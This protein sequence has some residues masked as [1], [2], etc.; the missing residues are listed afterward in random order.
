MRFTKD[1]LVPGAAVW[2][3]TKTSHLVETETFAPL[4]G[5]DSRPYPE[6]PYLDHALYLRH[7]QVVPAAVLQT[8]DQFELGVGW[9][10][11][12]LRQQEDTH[13][14]SVDYSLS[15]NRLLPQL[16]HLVFQKCGTLAVQGWQE[17]PPRHATLTLGLYADVYQP[18]GRPNVKISII[19]FEGQWFP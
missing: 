2:G 17:P 3:F 15:N 6:T 9:S 12:A 19:N 1:K 8:P 11:V 16:C 13:P 5:L 14:P 4:S 7:D 10:M 18:M